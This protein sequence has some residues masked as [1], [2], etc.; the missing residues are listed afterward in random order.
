[1][2]SEVIQ[3]VLIVSI[4]LSLLFIIGGVYL[5][6]KKKVSKYNLVSS[7]IFLSLGICF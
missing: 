6:K 1:M 5:S 2:L 3:L 4:F 7:F